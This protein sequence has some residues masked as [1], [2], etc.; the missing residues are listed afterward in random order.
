MLITI[1]VD[2]QIPLTKKKTLGNDVAKPGPHMAHSHV[3]GNG[4]LSDDCV[5][6]MRT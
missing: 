6:G 5:R 2:R 1:S 4:M 3:C